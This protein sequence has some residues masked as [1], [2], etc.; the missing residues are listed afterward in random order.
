MQTVEYVGSFFGLE[1]SHP[2]IPLQFERSLPSRSVSDARIHLP[3]A[4]ARSL[5]GRLTS[6][7]S[8]LFLNC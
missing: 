5:E 4:L 6:T 8:R 7:R 3:R 1:R 2:R